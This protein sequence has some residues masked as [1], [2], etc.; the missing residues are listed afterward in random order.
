MKA[1]IPS[2]RLCFFCFIEIYL[3]DG[4]GLGEVMLFHS[5]RGVKRSQW[6]VKLLKVCV[7]V[8]SMVQI[9]AQTSYQQTFLLQNKKIVC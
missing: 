8:S 4:D 2:K 5:G 1:Q 7:A 6:M 9:M 3:Q